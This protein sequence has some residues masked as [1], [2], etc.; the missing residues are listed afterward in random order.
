M[1][2]SLLAIDLDGTLLDTSGKPHPRDVLAVR[3]A[4]T[5]GISVSIVTGRLYSGTRASASV[6]GLQGPV[7]CADG[8]H[9]VLSLDHATLDH[10]G[11]TGVG[12]GRL[13]AA[14]ARAGLATF[15]FAEDAIGHDPRGAEFV[16]YVRTWSNDIRASADVYEHALWDAEGGVTAIVA[17][18][19]KESVLQA[20]QELGDEL[21]ASVY[22]VQFPLRREPHVGLWAIMA[23]ASGRTKG[24]AVRWIAEREGV[25]LKDVV[26]VGDWVNDIPMFEVAGRSF[27]MG[28]APDEVKSRATDV[29][30]ETSESGGGIAAAVARAFGIVPATRS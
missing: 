23:R 14:L 2:R 19:P 15:V 27:A 21:K 29:L 11:V 9:V 22:L 12:L 3:A 16:P 1:R 6:L 30:T 10:A 4:L 25:D 5:A 7:G 26:C 20:T 8:S 13:R 28:Q 17:L 18:G 24:T